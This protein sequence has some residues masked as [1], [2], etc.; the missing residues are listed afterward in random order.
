MHPPKPKL[1]SW[2]HTLPTLVPAGFRYSIHIVPA[3]PTRTFA[4][5]VS[6]PDEDAAQRSRKMAFRREVE[7]L[8]TESSKDVRAA[9][10]KSL[11]QEAKDAHMAAEPSPSQPCQM[12]MAVRRLVR[13]GRRV[14]GGV[15]MIC[16]QANGMPVEVSLCSATRGPYAAQTLP[17]PRAI[18][19]PSSWPISQTSRRSGCSTRSTTGYQCLSTTLS[20]AH[21]TRGR[22]TR[23]ISFTL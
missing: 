7:G 14:E 8:V 20:S 1:P 23:G 9:K 11:A 19:S 18:T 22:I 12:Y 13:Y 2:A 3:A 10:A 4:D 15:T 21:Y 16:C 5:C 17:P 6:L